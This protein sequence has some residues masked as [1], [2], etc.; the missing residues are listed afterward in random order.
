M[1]YRGLT[2]DRE[3]LEYKW[4]YGLPS[5]GYET[6]EVAEIGTPYGDFYEINPETLGKKGFTYLGED[7]EDCFAFEKTIDSN[8]CTFRLRLPF[9]E[10]KHRIMF[11]GDTIETHDSWS[12][13]QWQRFYKDEQDFME[14]WDKLFI[15]EYD[16]CN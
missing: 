1:K 3:K 8:E 12:N 14:N 5:Y 6:E 2:W 11:R 9:E 7:G 15:F 13:C 10:T 4:V 16:A